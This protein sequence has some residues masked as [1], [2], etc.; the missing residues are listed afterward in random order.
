VLQYDIKKRYDLCSYCLYRQFAPVRK[1]N[2]SVRRKI[3]ALKNETNSCYICQGLMGQ[4]DSIIKKLYDDVEAR[5]YE[6][7]SFLLGASLHYAIFERED[8]IRARFKIRGKENIKKQ[9]LDELRKKYHKAT[10]KRAKHISPDITINVV[11]GNAVINY[12]TG[13]D[14]HKNKKYNGIDNNNND[15]LPT[16]VFVKSSPIFLSGRYVKT[17][18]GISQKKDKCQK[19]SGSGCAT[20]NYTGASSSNSV[21]T[22]I[23]SRLLEIT[24]GDTWK[25]SWLGGE[26]KDS[27][28]LGNGRPFVLQISNPKVRWLKTGLTLDENGVCAVLKQ[29]LSLS[30]V[31]LPSQFTTKTKI[32]I[33]AEQDLTNQTLPKLLKVLENSE[34]SYQVKSKIVKKK[35]YSL[36]GQQV[37]E[38]RFVL[39]MVADGGLFIK[40]FV[41]GQDYIEPS[42]SK[43]IGIRCQ[44]VSFDILDVNVH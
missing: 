8:T 28:V 13:E 35:I 10:G 43:L 41:G 24:K 9:F 1:N 19:C 25:F 6:Y 20:C 16:T 27:L 14:S 37:D 42:I 5:G 33:Q 12:A 32:T 3:N 22:T 38:K 11:I 7:E 36:N 31:K 30:S 26:D 2:G 39:T 4:L 15:T 40:Q 17:I 34:V 18:R 23:G 29:Q 21:E 44:C